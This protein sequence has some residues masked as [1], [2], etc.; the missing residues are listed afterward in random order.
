MNGRVEA[1]RHGRSGVAREGLD[2]TDPPERIPWVKP[3]LD[4]DESLMADIHAALSSGRVTNDGPNLREF[5]RRLASYLGAEDCVAVSSGSAALLL[6]I[7]ALELRGGT[8]VLPAFTF[9]ATLNA[10][11]LAGMTP[12]FCD[13]EPDTWTMNPVHLTG[14]LAADPSIR[15]VVPVNVFGVQPDVGAV[16]RAIG[17]RAPVLLLDNA[18]G[19]GTEQ[20]GA[21]CPPEVP[22]QAYSFHATKLLPAVEG[23]AVVA[24]DP[25]LLAE[26]RRLRNHGVASDPL[27][28]APGFNAKMSELHAAVGLRS[29]RGL[30]AALARRREY[31]ERLRRTMATDCAEAFTVQAIPPGMR[32]NFQNLGVLCRRA[33]CS[34]VAAVQT[35]LDRAGIETRRYFWPPLHQLRAYRGRCSLPVTEA[36]S[37]AILCLPLHSRMDPPVLERI[38]EAL[39]RAAAPG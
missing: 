25:R 6:A 17:S 5:E 2:V 11:L 30:D 33:G 29:L 27:A 7:W 36:V 32:S 38:E 13:I 16:R 22:L 19:F 31:A 24:T 34:N 15:L 3:I 20:G 9:P 21:R 23:G 35:A 10:I 14:L 12:V 37:E 39:R 18:H 4:P 1:A 8:A 26:I 28:S